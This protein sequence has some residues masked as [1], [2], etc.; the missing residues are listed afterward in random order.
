[1]KKILLSCLAF[2]AITVALFFLPFL[3]P[4][5]KT[6]QGDI[7]LPWQIEL[8]EAGQTR[9]FGLYPGI[10]SL[11]DVIARFGEEMEIAVMVA[12]NIPREEITND[13]ALEGYYNRVSLDFIQTRMVLSLD[14]PQEM[15]TAMLA[16]SINVEYMRNGS[17]KFI[18]HPDDIRIAKTMPIAAITLVPNARI[19][20]E[21]VA[22]RF[23][24][25]AEVITTGENLQH[26][27]YPDK[28]LDIVLDSKGKNI[29]QYVAPAE[30][31]E[32]IMRP[33]RPKT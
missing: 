10:S 6:P 12:A 17:R 5:A 19:D 11:S 20:A 29:L 27:L 25:P 15:I 18:L 22:S 14:A 26:Y 4:V 23:G 30:F 8:D 32:R 3:F 31:E 33:L 16:R 21:A 2:V 28:G 9:V 7:G 13:A 24:R 1:M